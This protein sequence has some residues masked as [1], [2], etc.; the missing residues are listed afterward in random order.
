MVLAATSPLVFLALLAC[1]VGMGLMMWF[2]SRGMMGGQRHDEMSHG[3]EASEGSLAELKAEHARL[4]E[5]IEALESE[6]STTPEPAEDAP[7]GA[8]ARASGSP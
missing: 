1:P 5:R 3:D 7:A 4:G 6:R 8:T 2:M